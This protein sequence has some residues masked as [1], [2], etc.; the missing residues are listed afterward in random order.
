MS[1][2]IDVL[3]ALATRLRGIP[4]H[5]PELVR[6]LGEEC[7]DLIKAGHDDGAGPYGD[8]WE[9]KADGSDCHLTSSGNLRNGW[10]ISSASASEVTVS[11]TAFY[12]AVHNGGKLIRAKNVPYLRFKVG[13]RWVRRKWVRIPIRELVP[14]SRGLPDE[15]ADTLKETA[16]LTIAHLVNGK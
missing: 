7:I 10:H 2:S 8:Q 1:D 9:P 14:D 12:A 11:P 6:Q 16:E 15:W 13:G 5:M 3:A 4:A